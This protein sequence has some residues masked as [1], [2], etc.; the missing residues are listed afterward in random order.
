MN[1]DV[2]AELLFHILNSF[3]Q[4]VDAKQLLN[5]VNETST[6]YLL[7]AYGKTL[8]FNTEGELL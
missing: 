3:P 1:K 2:E 5:Q 7:R 4:E 6:G 8:T